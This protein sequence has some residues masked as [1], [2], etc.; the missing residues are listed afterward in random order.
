MPSLWHDLTVYKLAFRELIFSPSFKK[1]LQS[2]EREREKKRERERER[3]RERKTK[4]WWHRAHCARGCLVDFRYAHT[5]KCVIAL[6]WT[7]P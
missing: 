5:H 3:E 7:G 6:S 2:K 1:A 4:A